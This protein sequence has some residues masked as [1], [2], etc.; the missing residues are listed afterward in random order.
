MRELKI[1]EIDEQQSEEL[2][3][4]IIAILCCNYSINPDAKRVIDEIKECRSG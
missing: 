4:K 2:T 1:V 3:N